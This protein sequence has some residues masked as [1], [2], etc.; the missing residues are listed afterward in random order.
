[1]FF[2]P[3]NVEGVL[4]TSLRDETVAIKSKF[5]CRLRGSNP[6]FFAFDAEAIA[7]SYQDDNICLF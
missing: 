5:V 4:S 2:L 3:S 6:S 1:M 7:V